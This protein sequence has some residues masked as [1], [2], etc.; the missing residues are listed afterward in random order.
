MARLGELLIAAGELNAHEIEQAVRAQIMWGGRLGTNLVELGYIDLDKLATALC[1]QHHLPAALARHF[2]KSD[3]AVAARLD[4]DIAER[5]SVVPLLYAGPKRESVIIASLGPLDKRA[6]AIIADDMRLEPTSIVVSVAGELRIRYHLERVYNI[7]RGSRFLRSKGKTI[8]PFPQF[9]IDPMSFEDSAVDVPVLE[10]H[11]KPAPVPVL[12]EEDDEVDEAALEEIRGELRARL[13]EKA[14]EKANT[15]PEM[16]PESSEH[17]TIQTETLFDPADVHEHDA[18]SVLGDDVVAI[19]ERVDGEKSSGRERRRYVETLDA[20]PR[21]LDPASETSLGRIVI[22][23]VAL[24][25]AVEDEPSSMGLTLGE[26]TRAIR[27]STDRER[28]AELVNETLFRFMLSCDAALM[29]VVRG[30]AAMSWKGFSRAGAALP[31]IAVPVD[32]P[33][34]IPRA[35][36]HCKTVRARSSDLCPIDQLLLVSLGHESGELVVVPV[37]IASQVMCVI[38][39]AAQHDSSTATAESVAAAA[40]A[41]FARLMRNA[42][43]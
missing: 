19:P 39:L 2:E 11:I 23:R 31:E 28:V 3:P 24:P 25:A 17:P 43:R 30:E 32:Q 29:L 5:Y 36:E 16:E 14:A 33:G 40:G 18:R 41:A 6:V 22:K 13:E 42:S 10:L 4:P 20:T 9:D 15:E 27:R 7:P 34:L 1:K 35:I 37:S 26:A 38:A 12:P 8:P 21:N